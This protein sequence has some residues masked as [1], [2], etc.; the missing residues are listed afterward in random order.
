MKKS[1]HF[2]PPAIGGSS[3]M[4][5]FALLAMCI[6]A[7]LS[8]T[9]AKAEERLSTVSAQAVADYY[10]ADLQAEKQFAALRETEKEAGDFGYSCPV[11]E[12][13]QLQVRLRFDGKRWQI[14]QWQTVA[15]E[16]PGIQE[17][18]KLWDG[19]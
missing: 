8:L 13:R 9:T 15:G 10:A 5:I 2:S 16:E 1:A 14:L 6:F 18:L 7:V 4:V 11:S 19:E 3:L 17:T 12:N